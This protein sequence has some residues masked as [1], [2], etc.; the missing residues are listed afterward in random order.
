MSAWCRWE[1][2]SGFS[3]AVVLGLNLWLSSGDVEGWGW[4]L[5]FLLA[6]P[7]GIVGLWIRARLEESPEFVELKKTDEVLS[8][9]LRDVLRT[10]PAGVCIAIAFSLFHNASLYVIVTYLPSHIS[11]E[12]GLSSTTASVSSVA[13]MAVMCALIPVFGWLSDRT[14]RKPILMCS[15]ILML[16]LAYPLFLGMDTGITAVIVLAHL[17]LGAILAVFLGA[18]MATLTEFFKPEERSSGLGVGYNVA[19]SLFGGTAPFFMVLMIN[20]FNTLAAPGW[21]LVAASVV[22][23]I[24]ICCV[25][26]TAPVRQKSETAK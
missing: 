7:L 1:A 20:G 11:Q 12:L 13:N 4:R 6:G 16:V 26:E 5:P 18:T 10:T 14:G 3:S 15:C 17:L 24:A 19:V 9:P 21:Y 23:G 25:R 8:T 22:S 2:S